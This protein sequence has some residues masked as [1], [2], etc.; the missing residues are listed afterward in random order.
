MK[1]YNRLALLLLTAGLAG[2]GSDLG[3]SKGEVLSSGPV[4][5]SPPI[6]SPTAAN[7]ATVGFRAV[8]PGQTGATK[9][10]LNP[11]MTRITI[12]A[13]GACGVAS[14]E[15]TPQNNTGIMNLT[16]GEC[17]FFA[18]SYDSANAPLD[19]AKTQG[20]LLEGANKVSLMF[21]GGP[22]L[23]V[24]P[25]TNEKISLTLA[26]NEVLTGLQ[27]S[28]DISGTSTMRWIGP[29]LTL[30]GPSADD[31][32]GGTTLT[33]LPPLRI[34]ATFSGGT[35]AGANQVQFTAA[36][37]TSNL[38]NWEPTYAA[39]DRVI[40]I[41]G[42][43]TR[44]FNP[45]SF[46][47]YHT[48]RVIDGTTMEGNIAELTVE[49][50]IAGTPYGSCGVASKAAETAALTEALGIARKAQTPIGPVTMTWTQCVNGQY[51]DMVESYSSVTIHPFRAKSI[52][53]APDSPLQI[54]LNAA[55]YSY[56]QAQ[57]T[58][59]PINGLNMTLLRQA[60]AQFADALTLAGDDLSNTADTVRFFSAINRLAAL[61]IDTTS[62]GVADGLNDFND[63]LDALGVPQD[64]ASRNWSKTATTTPE[65]CDP[66]FPYEC[67]PN[68]PT[69]SP[70]SGEILALLDTRLNTQLDLAIADLA[71]IAAG[72][73][74]NYVGPYEVINFDYGDVLA[75]TA[76]AYGIK[77]EMAIDMAYDLNLDIDATINGT[78][79]ASVQAFMD[80][81]PNLGTL[82]A[83]RY[84]TE[85]AQAK[86]D[87]QTG[88]NKM[89]E[90]IDVI[91]LEGTGP[92]QENEFISFYGS[93][94]ECIP[95]IPYGTGCTMTEID[96]TAEEI[97]N[98]RDA[99]SKTLTGLNGPV[100][101]DDNMTPA[102]TADDTI[103]NPSKFF[104]GISFRALI[105]TFT[106]DVANGLFP[107]PSM[108]GILVQTPNLNVNQDF[109]GNNVPDLIEDANFY[110][111]LLN[112]KAY[113]LNGFSYNGSIWMKGM[114]EVK[115]SSFRFNSDGTVAA[116]WNYNDYYNPPYGTI[117]GTATGTWSI[118]STGDLQILFSA[119]PLNLASIV[120]DLEE[121][122]DALA[123]PIDLKAEMTFNYSDF[124]PMDQNY[125]NW[126]EKSSVSV[127]VR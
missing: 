66:V 82:D 46:A 93:D 9:A 68:L 49:S 105:P 41:L 110:P 1:I 27:V 80:A 38:T 42:A 45:P 90:A 35:G 88:L 37:G 77:A 57:Q 32:L 89:T 78:G 113:E 26:G 47:D 18:T 7:K 19:S 81:N 23:F 31:L 114:Y 13:D 58:E 60:S 16:P 106:G 99:I 48:S 94:W 127:I 118:L 8:F 15:L 71:K 97:A 76:M 52:F 34:S 22:W 21:L 17:F 109:D 123:S 53:A 119:N 72:F 70:T 43:S 51:Q 117:S 10:T 108:G 115:W 102:N 95:N 75:L 50:I 85:L 69:S 79:P 126:Y 6:T 63:V 87:L 29:D 100:T 40:K 101:V 116:D 14:L 91:E 112:N 73:S 24:D 125:L 121:A 36:S 4:I 3:G 54:A 61:A 30:D 65:N 2:C 44:T 84:V 67:T 92:S 104:D 86:V 103:I 98:F 25:A 5:T 11:L 56:N 83:S 12:A 33:S 20:I 107:D 124:T 62:D 120:A 96:R 59:D 111:A 55:V 74:Y 39:G 122:V 28:Q 64:A